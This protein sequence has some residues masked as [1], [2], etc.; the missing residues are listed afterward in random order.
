M[1]VIFSDKIVFRDTISSGYIHIKD[2]LIERITDSL[3]INKESENLIDMSGKYILPGII[4]IHSE[5]IYRENIIKA[6]G[7]FPIEKI[8]REVEKRCTSSGITTL[9]H[10][11]P[12]IHGRHQD[13]FTTGP[14]LVRK[15]KELSKKRTLIDHRTHMEF[16]L[17]YLD[18]MDKLKELL[19]SGILD[20]ISYLGYCRSDEERYRE[21]YYKDYIQ[22]SMGLDDDTCMK[23]VERVRELRSE[24]NLEELAY[25]LKYAHYKGMKVA[26]AELNSIRKL[27]FLAKHGINIIEFPMDRETID[28]ARSTEKKV[29]ADTMSLS[30][31]N[32]AMPE[33]DM[34]KAVKDGYIDMLSADIR[35]YD[36][37]MYTFVL[38]K[39]IGLSKAAQLVTINPAEALDLHD[40]GEIKEGLR[41]DIIAVELIEEVP[42]VSMTMSNGKISYRT[43]Y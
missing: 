12:L 38:A 17:G 27:E 8:F 9:Y 13:D 25:M 43:E 3:E 22:R 30:K 2:G 5:H 42:V 4:N 11:M 23:M 37:L 16:Q 39:E 36:L 26:S 21:V 40:R 10:S 7:M 6:N 24:S 14:N 15:I 29:L 32:G 28:F 34:Y 19:E 41:A 35:A 20:Y 1:S 18:S 33:I 31:A